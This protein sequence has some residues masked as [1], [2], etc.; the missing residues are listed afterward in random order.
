MS[1]AELLVQSVI[2]HGNID[3]IHIANNDIDNIRRY[4]DKDDKFSYA[5]KNKND[6]FENDKESKDINV[7]IYRYKFED[8]FTEELLKFSKIH[9]YDHRKDFKEAWNIWIEANDEIINNEVRRLKNLGYD[10]NVNDKMFKSARYYFRTKSTEKKAPSERR[11]YIGVRKDLLQAMDKHV[12]SEIN[13]VDYKPSDGF[14]EFCKKNKDILNDEV[15]NL[16]KNGF[17]D[18]KEIKNKIKKTYKNRYFLII[19]K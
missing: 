18:P 17:R 4:D 10:G 5:T 9:Q 15:K 8:D 16:Y 11:D 13:N 19:N 1:N 6:V 2:N 3:V 12:K 7:N 14:E